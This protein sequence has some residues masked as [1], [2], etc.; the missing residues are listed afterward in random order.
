MAPPPAFRVPG[1]SWAD[2]FAIITAELDRWKDVYRQL[3]EA[4]ARLKLENEHAVNALAGT[5]R[6]T[7]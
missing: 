4:H 1:P 5:R 6:Q 7:K 3:R 2:D